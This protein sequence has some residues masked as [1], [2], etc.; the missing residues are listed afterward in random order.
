VTTFNPPF[1]TIED[2]LYSSQELLTSPYIE[3]V[4]NQ[5]ITMPYEFGLTKVIHFLPD[6]PLEAVI[7]T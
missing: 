5:P 6:M 1:W 7:R 3:L 2:G 4:K